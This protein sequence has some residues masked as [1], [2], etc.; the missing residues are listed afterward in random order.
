MTA[1]AQAVRAELTKVFTTRMWWVLAIIMVAYV[2]FTAVSIGFGLGYATDGAESSGFPLEFDL[3]AMTYS[4]AVTVGFVFAV[5]LGALSVTGEYRHQTVTPT[6]LA[7]P[8]RGVALAAKLTVQYGLGAFYGVLAFVGS[9]GLGAL[10]LAI[11]GAGAQL[12]QASTWLLILRGIIAMG[13]WA[14]I[15]V[16]LG[17]LVRN[18]VAASVIVVAFTQFVEPL[19]RFGSM[20]NST[21]GAIGQFLP[22]AASDALVGGSFYSLMMAGGSGSQLEW[23]SGGLVLVAYAVAATIGGYFTSWRK[24]VT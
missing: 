4:T 6:F 3:A 22:G 12:D 2:G 1:F 19:L 16:G 24:D 14:G 17:A 21:A 11:S 10:G 7:V 23:W 13:L 20:I 15:G 8:Q 5:L 9:V 18:Q